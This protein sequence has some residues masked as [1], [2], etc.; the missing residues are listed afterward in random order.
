MRLDELPW[1]LPFRF[2][3]KIRLPSG[4][5]LEIYRYMLSVFPSQTNT[6]YNFVL[7]PVRYKRELITWL[8]MCPLTAQAV[9]YECLARRTWRQRLWDKLKSWL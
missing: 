6:K 3:C 5:G 4:E 7:T 8:N 9:L 2:S 1:D